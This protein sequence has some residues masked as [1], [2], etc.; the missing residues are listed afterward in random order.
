[1]VRSAADLLINIDVDD[2]E[3]AI[4]FY[5]Q[6]FGLEIGRRFGDGGVEMTGAATPIYLLVR[7]AG[8]TPATGV[9]QRRD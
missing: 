5:S 8:S 1:M 3:K 7:S 2:L 9:A 6:A 4:A